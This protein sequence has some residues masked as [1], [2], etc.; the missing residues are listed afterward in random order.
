MLTNTE[1]TIP[2]LPIIKQASVSPKV[3]VPALSA[4]FVSMGQLWHGFFET[5]KTKKTTQ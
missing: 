5:K 2:K 1:S 4:V 3:I